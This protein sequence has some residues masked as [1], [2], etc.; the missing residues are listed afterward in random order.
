MNGCQYDATEHSEG[1]QSTW[2]T[3]SSHE[4]ERYNIQHLLLASDY[5]MAPPQYFIQRP[6]AVTAHILVV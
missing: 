1:R 2:Q 6:A 5:Q 3:T 4:G